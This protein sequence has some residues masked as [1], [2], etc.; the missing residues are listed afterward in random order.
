MTAA[1]MEWL[2][3]SVNSIVIE[4]AERQIRE[5]AFADTNKQGV[6]ENLITVHIRWGDKWQEM[7]LVSIEKYLDATKKL[8]TDDELDGK[9]KVHIYVA[10]EDSRA[11]RLYNDSAPDHW[12]IHSSGPTTQSSVTGEDQKMNDIAKI[13]EG[14]AGL[15]SLAALL[16]S[17][18]A[19]RYVLATGSNWSRLINELRKNVVN[20]PMWR[21]YT[22]SRVCG[23]QEIFLMRKIGYLLLLSQ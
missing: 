1:T 20:P 13:S 10:S 5:E 4:E 9:K 12:I 6:P 15:E 8:L 11:L 19:N 17:M 14:R 2:F 23:P 18:E 3:Q 21:V 7:K 16:I 22:A